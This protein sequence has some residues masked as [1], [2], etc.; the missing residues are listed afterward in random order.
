MS[1]EAALVQEAVRETAEAAEATGGLG[2]LGIN[3]KIFLA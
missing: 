3:V 1:Y 2:T